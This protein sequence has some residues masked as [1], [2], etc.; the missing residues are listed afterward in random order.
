MC[1]HIDDNFRNP[2]FVARQNYVYLQLLELHM[3]KVASILREQMLEPVM[4]TP[5]WFLT[6]FSKSLS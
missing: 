6:L 3:P 4:Y 1:A 2:G 5:S